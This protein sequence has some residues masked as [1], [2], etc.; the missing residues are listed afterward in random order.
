MGLILFVN[1][2]L[3]IKFHKKT[4]RTPP[5]PPL[6]HPK[7][8]LNAPYVHQ[9]C[10]VNEPYVLVKFTLNAPMMQTAESLCTLRP[11]MHPKRN[12]YAP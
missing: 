3:E 10:T 4:G 5:P 6:T 9:K 11:Y 12:P 8:S 7:F 2:Y 1:C